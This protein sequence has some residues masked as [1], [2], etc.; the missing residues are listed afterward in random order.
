MYTNKQEIKNWLD[1][2]EIKNY[3]INEDLYVDVNGDVWLD[4]KILTEI[5]VKFNI[6]K[7]IFDCDNNQLTSTEFL[8]KEVYILNTHFHNKRKNKLS[9]TIKVLRK[10][11]HNFSISYIQI[12]AHHFRYHA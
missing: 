8:P 6:I 7:G 12:F 4:N 10:K 1:E 3:S 11:V 5:P 2:N 9:N